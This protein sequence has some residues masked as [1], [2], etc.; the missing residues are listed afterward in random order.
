MWRC[1]ALAVVAGCSIEP[2]SDGPA[3][4]GGSTGEGSDSSTTSSTTTGISATEP[5]VEE[6]SSSSNESS[7]SSEESSS[8]TSSGS[9]ESSSS[10]SSGTASAPVV[11]ELSPAEGDVGVIAIQPVSVT[12]DQAMEPASITVNLDA[13]CTGTLQL[14]ADDFATCVPM[15]GDPVTADDTT[16]VLTPAQDY[17]SLG[18]YRVRVL[19]AVQSA[20]G[21]A[22]DDTFTSEPFTVRYFHTIAIDGANDFA[23][24]ETFAT[25]SDGHTA[26]TAWDSNYVYFGM[27]SP[28]VA[29]GNDE[30]WILAYFGGT[31]GTDIGVGYNTQQPAL[32]F[33]ARYHVRWKASNDFT[34]VMEFDGADWQ[35]DGNSFELNPGDIYQSGEFVELRVSLFDLALPAELHMHVGIVRES[36][37]SEA[38]WAAHP[39]GSYVDGY[40]PDYAEYWAFDVDLSPIAPVDYVSL[41]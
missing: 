26:Y 7:S 37:F 40:D 9:S 25:S 29:S 20:V 33:D 23:G 21:V 3:T 22:M 16:F 4:F 34:D 2:R 35:V 19:S 5:P 14:S 10:S 28:D 18:Q 15:V 1:V 17:A 39:G 13:A 41:P 36:D 31:P 27:D 8:R 38:S 24:N 12:F 6:S 11:V 32:P 30:V